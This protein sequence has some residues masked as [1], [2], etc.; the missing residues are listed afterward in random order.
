MPPPLPAPLIRSASG[1][2]AFQ[3]GQFTLQAVAE[4][5][6]EEEEDEEE[7]DKGGEEVSVHIESR[8]DD[9]KREKVGIPPEKVP[10]MT[11]KNV[12][13]I[14][15]RALLPPP[16]L[17][18]VSAPGVLRGGRGGPPASPGSRSRGSRYTRTFTSEFPK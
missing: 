1:L 8:E 11:K 7:D 16:L 18:T 12:F 9:N 15:S 4:E 3:Q 10:K 2:L 17:G 14:N 13:D 5:E 6:G